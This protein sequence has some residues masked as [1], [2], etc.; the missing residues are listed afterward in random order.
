[1]GFFGAPNLLQD[2]ATWACRT[3]LLQQK[4]IHE[5]NAKWTLE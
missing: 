3:A 2:H 1:M 5:L 4:T